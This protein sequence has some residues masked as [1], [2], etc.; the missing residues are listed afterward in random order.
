[1][2]ENNQ[3]IETGAIKKLESI[4]KCNAK[5]DVDISGFKNSFTALLSANP[6]L[7]TFAEIIVI[8]TPSYPHDAMIT[9]LDNA[10]AANEFFSYQFKLLIAVVYCFHGKLLP[11][12]ERKWQQGIKDSPVDIE[13]RFFHIDEIIP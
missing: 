8:N 2:E 13:L 4:F 7:Y 3:Q 9:L 11:E 6:L 10:A 12:I 5:I 1:M